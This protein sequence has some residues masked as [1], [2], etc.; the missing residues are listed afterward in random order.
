MKTCLDF[1]MSM[2]STTNLPEGLRSSGCLQ[3]SCSDFLFWDSCDNA[4]YISWRCSSLIW[5][6]VLSFFS[7]ADC[8]LAATEKASGCSCGIVLDL[9]VVK[10]VMD[11]STP[12]KLPAALNNV[13]IYMLKSYQT[14]PLVHLRWCLA[15][16]DHGQVLLKHWLQALAEGLNT[17]QERTMIKSYKYSTTHNEPQPLRQWFLGLS[18][19]LWPTAAKNSFG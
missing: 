11:K 17:V 1:M 14:Q 13:T 4:G 10:R 2:P 19:A 9:T 8:L 16:N 7:E 5:S 12:H 18:E 3:L 15:L 6:N